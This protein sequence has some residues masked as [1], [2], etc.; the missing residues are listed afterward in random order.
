MKTGPFIERAGIIVRM[1]FVP[2]NTEAAPFVQQDN[3]H[4]NRNSNEE[5]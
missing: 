2:E 5:S 4:G 1:R 3:G